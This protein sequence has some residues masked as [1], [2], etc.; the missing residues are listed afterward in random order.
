MAAMELSILF[1]F[2]ALSGYAYMCFVVFVRCNLSAYAIGIFAQSFRRLHGEFC[3]CASQVQPAQSNTQKHGD[4]EPGSAMT[5]PRADRDGHE[6][7]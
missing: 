4:K 7:H 6:P 1:W 3:N 2:L 5:V